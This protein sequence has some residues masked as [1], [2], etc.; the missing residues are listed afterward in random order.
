MGN[1]SQGLDARMFRDGL[2]EQ[3]EIFEEPVVHH[4]FVGHAPGAD[5]SLGRPKQ[6]IF[7]SSDEMATVNEPTQSDVQLL[8][9]LYQLGDVRIETRFPIQ[10]PQ[11][12]QGT[13]GDEFEFRGH[14]WRLLGQVDDVS[15]GGEDGF[16]KAFLRRI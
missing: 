11:D 4:R 2:E 5:P 15:F 6:A 1:L 9:G 8:G 10:S 16:H 14:R 13:C 3:A 7:E 12:S